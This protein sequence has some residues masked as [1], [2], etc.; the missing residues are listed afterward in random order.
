[1]P[2]K[3]LASY[4]DVGGDVL[5]AARNPTN[6]ALSVQLG[7]S[8]NG[9]V[10]CDNAEWWQHVGFASIPSRAEPGKPACQVLSLEEADRDVCYASRDLRVTNIYGTLANGETCVYAAGPEGQGTSRI[11]LKDNGETAT[12]TILVQQGN[13]SSGAPVLIQISSEGKIIVS[14]GQH[15]AVSID[16]DGIKLVSN[17]DLQLGASGNTTLIGQSLALN[18]A[19]VS[20]GANATNPVALATQLVALLAAYQAAFAAL[21]GA[22]GTGV[23]TIPGPTLATLTAALTAVASLSGNVA[24]VPSTSVFAAT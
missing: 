4:G 7:D 3:S 22:L 21:A 17:S 10:T 18:A 20:I 15:G 23:V 6:G 13:T 16:S 5:G 2:A 24:Q 1:M 8:V 12:T 9:E 14:A 11:L 19:N